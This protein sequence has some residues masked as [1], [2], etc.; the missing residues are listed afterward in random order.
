MFEGQQRLKMSKRIPGRGWDALRR[1]RPRRRTLVFH[2]IKVQRRSSRCEQL[3]WPISYVHQTKIEILAVVTTIGG[4]II[5]LK[6]V[7]ADDI[8]SSHQRQQRI[9]KS[10]GSFFLSGDRREQALVVLVSAS[11]L[12]GGHVKF[13]DKNRFA[14]QRMKRVQ[15]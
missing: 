4:F 1:V 2:C 15:I 13:A 10:D 7:G 5:I 9:A 6:P 11:V 8:R 14:L 12:P 3:V